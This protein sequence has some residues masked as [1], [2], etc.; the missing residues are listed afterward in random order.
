[1]RNIPGVIYLL[2]TL[3]V[4]FAI[5]APGFAT[6]PNLLNIGTQS[7]I[8]L[9]LALPMTLIIMTEGLD[10]SMGAV[11]G[12]AGVVLAMLKDSLDAFVT[13]RVDRALAV[14]PRDR[15][16]DEMYRRL[17]QDLIAAMTRK[18]SC[19]P[20]CL[21]LLVICKS[22]ERIGDHATNVAEDVVYLYEGRDI[23]HPDISKPLNIS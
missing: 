21:G 2:A 14:I 6:L 17:Q 18:P 10:L 5:V 1:M 23:R 8:L 9:L 11:L 16:A 19:V 22:L 15:G 12:L 7:S 4:L 20:R 3:F 13:G